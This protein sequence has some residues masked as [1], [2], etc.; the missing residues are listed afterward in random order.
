MKILTEKHKKKISISLKRAIDEGRRVQHFSIAAKKKMSE[1]HLGQIAWNKGK[2]GLKG[3][4]HGRWNGGVTYHEMGYRYIWNPDHPYC[5]KKGYVR[6]HR[7]VMEQKI[8]RYLLPTE[9]VHHINGD[10]ADN[11]IENLAIYASEH[12]H[13]KLGHHGRRGVKK[14]WENYLTL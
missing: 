10:T 5:N 8:G 11:R 2:P 12:D 1:S 4:K 9:I 13:W 7:L 14:T 6:E 3:K